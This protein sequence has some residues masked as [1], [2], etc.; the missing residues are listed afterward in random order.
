MNLLIFGAPGSGKGTQARLLVE[1]MRGVISVISLGDLLRAEVAS[2]TEVGKEIEMVMQAGK[3][4]SDPLVCEVILRQL[5]K[6]KT[7]GFL[8]DGFPRN[9][10]QA[11]FLTAALEL[12]G[13][14]I[15]AVLKLDV[16]A[17]VLVDRLLGRMVCVECGVVSN[18]MFSQA[19]ACGKCGSTSYSRRTDDSGSVIR[20]RFSIYEEFAVELEQYYGEKVLVIDGNRPVDEVHADIKH[21]VNCL[22]N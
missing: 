1:S 2:D 19:E 3:L 22:N 5:R 10:P 18:A 6:V 16:D 17:N 12:L 20:Q 21:R 15:S 14:E 11:K 9:M 13:K 7:T 4:V 8:L